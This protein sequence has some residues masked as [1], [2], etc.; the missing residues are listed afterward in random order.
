MLSRP[1]RDS[2]GLRD[3]AR[4]RLRATTLDETEKRLR[5]LTFLN[6]LNRDLPKLASSH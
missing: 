3:A 5:L 2:G 6:A 1:C 4:R